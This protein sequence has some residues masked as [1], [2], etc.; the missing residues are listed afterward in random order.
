MDWEVRNK[1]YAVMPRYGFN[2]GNKLYAVGFFFA[3]LGLFLTFLWRRRFIIRSN[4][5]GCS[6]WL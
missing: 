1:H 5:E 2:E 6:R 3:G 4:R